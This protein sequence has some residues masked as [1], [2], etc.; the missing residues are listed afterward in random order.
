MKLTKPGMSDLK[1]E[2]LGSL[3][4][5]D[6]HL[7]QIRWEEDGRDIVLVLR[8]SGG[9]EAELRCTWAEGLALQIE[10]RDQGGMALTW[11]GSIERLPDGRHRVELDFSGE[12]RL[13]LV[14]NEVV[15]TLSSPG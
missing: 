1:A 14:C 11:A 7:S 15:G 6:A 8:R 3:N 2:D 5:G 10:K 4:W 12:G 9:E 13:S